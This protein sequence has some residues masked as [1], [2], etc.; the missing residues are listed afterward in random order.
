[1]SVFLEAFVNI[2]VTCFEKYDQKIAGG[3]FE[4]HFKNNMAL[5]NKKF[6]NVDPEKETCLGFWGLLST[7]STFQ[8]SCIE[9][10]LNIALQTLCCQELFATTLSAASQLVTTTLSS[11]PTGGFF[12]HF[13]KFLVI[14]T[15]GVYLDIL[16]FV[17]PLLLFL[18]EAICTGFTRIATEHKKAVAKPDT[19]QAT[20][21]YSK[22]E[23]RG[24]ILQAL[25]KSFGLFYCIV[26]I[27]KQIQSWNIYSPIAVAFINSKLPVT[28]L[29]L[30]GGAPAILSFCLAIIIGITIFKACQEI[31]RLPFVLRKINNIFPLVMFLYMG[32]HKAGTVA[33]VMILFR[34]GEVLKSISQGSIPQQRERLSRQPTPSA[35]QAM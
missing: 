17:F 30:T 24:Q 10:V 5:F 20:A 8:A 33:I 27:A 12:I 31:H 16:S 28:L 32:A 25:R 35:T 22:I 1:M 3:E 29:S 13:A 23:K 18:P 21:W 19:E 14:P 6:Q 15:T 4:G 34:L 9:S 26:Q 2:N 11:I 7:S